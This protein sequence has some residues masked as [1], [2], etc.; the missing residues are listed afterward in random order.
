MTPPLWQFSGAADG[1]QPVAGLVQGPNGN[2]Y[3]T[4][5]A[6]G[7]SGLGAVFTITPSG[8]LTPLY[9]FA[10]GTDGANPEGSLVFGSNNRFYGTAFGGGNGTGSVFRI[11]TAGGLA[12][13][14]NF[15]GGDDG[16]F[17]A[18]GLIV[19][20]DGNLYGTTSAEGAGGLGTVFRIT[21]SGGVTTLH[22]FSGLDG[23]TPLASLVQGTVSNFY[24][25]TSAGGTNNI[26][27]IFTLIQPC[28]YVLSSTHVTL[29]AID[30]TG[31]FTVTA[32][33]TNCPWVAISSTDWITITSTNSGFG[34]ETISYSV[35]ANTNGTARTGTISVEG[36]VF[37]INQQSEVLG[38]FLLGTYEGLVMDPVS[39]VQAS[40]GFISLAIGKTGTFTAKLM[41]GGVRSSFKGAFDTSGNFTN[42]VARKGLS[43]LQIILQLLDVTNETDQI[44]GTVSDGVFTVDL[45]ADLA[46]FSKVNPS[47]FAGNYTFVLE[48]ADDTDPTVRRDSGMA[49]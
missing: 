7:G 46:V 12:A 2:F 39:P 44:V 26:G 36:K 33:I 47:P 10:G 42:T 43:S 20:S 16:G 38:R 29:P 25:T 14:Y 4:T 48:P 18:A 3:G 24:G 15:M 49:H 9:N 21:P 45:Q 13:I 22:S 30:D 28:T 1:S 27:T 6:G 41:M 11:G 34:S 32:D 23:A 19:G 5:F 31:T 37:T 17:P 35:A 40:S 8:A